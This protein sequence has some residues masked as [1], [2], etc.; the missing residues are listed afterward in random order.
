MSSQ[1]KT[2]IDKNFKGIE[3]VLIGT[4]RQFVIHNGE[5]YCVRSTCDSEC[6]YFNQGCTFDEEEL[7]TNLIPNS[8]R[9]FG[10]EERHFLVL[11][12]KDGQSIHTL[13]K[14]LWTN[15]NDDLSMNPYNLHYITTDTKETFRILKGQI[16]Y[17]D[18]L[19]NFQSSK[20]AEYLEVFS[21]YDPSH[22]LFALDYSAVEPKVS[23]M[24]CREPEWL[25][26]FKGSP[27]NIVNEVSIEGLEEGN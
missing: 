24:V 18:S 3:A 27:K 23:T 2:K 5:H 9:G 8:R 6:P 17:Y 21:E 20:Y 19:E 12:F 1:S 11:L 10:I 13:P 4:P 26:I 15:E 25:K 14:E 22:Y 7:D 16:R